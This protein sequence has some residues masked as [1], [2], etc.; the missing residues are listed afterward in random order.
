MV[1]LGNFGRMRLAHARRGEPAAT[2][3]R[4]LR[5]GVLVEAVIGVVVLV[6]TTVLVQ[7]EPGRSASA[8]VASAATVT[9]IVTSTVVTASEWQT[10][11]VQG[12]WIMTVTLDQT[13]VGRRQLTVSVDDAAAP[14]RDPVEVQAR[15]TL[16]AENLGPIPVSLQATG[17]RT[18]SSDSVEFTSPGT[19]SLEVLLDD[20]AT[21]ARFATT[22]PI[23]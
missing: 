5:P 8:S 15:L 9:S 20:P 14:F 19:W 21:S 4:S 18:W 2:L 22:I 3:P 6:L 10:E 11:I 13:V 12:S 16:E 17:A 1:V 23:E 7:S